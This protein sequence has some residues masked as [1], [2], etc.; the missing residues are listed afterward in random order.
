MDDQIERIAAFLRQYV[1]YDGGLLLP[2][3]REAIKDAVSLMIE[4]KIMSVDEMRR[5]ALREYNVII[6]WDLFPKESQ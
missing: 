1:E 5:E 4:N 3:D 6:P 2:A